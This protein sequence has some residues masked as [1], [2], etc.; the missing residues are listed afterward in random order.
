MRADKIN[1]SFGR[2]ILIENNG[3]VVMTLEGYGR[4]DG[5]IGLTP[6]DMD[7]IGRAIFA[8][9][10]K[11]FS[12]AQS[13]S[14]TSSLPLSQSHFMPSSPNQR[15]GAMPPQAYTPWSVDDDDRLRQYHAGKKS[16]PDIAS[17]LGRNEGAIRSRLKKLK[18]Q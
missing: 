10:K 9:R 4:V 3:A 2:I 8:I 12:N 6:G 16:I 11:W 5:G 18:L 13:Q 17:L 15:I 1:L 14:K 7:K